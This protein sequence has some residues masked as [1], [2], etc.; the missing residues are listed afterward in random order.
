MEALPALLL[1]SRSQL[2]PARVPL[3]YAQT[4]SKQNS[5]IIEIAEG[6]LAPHADT[7]NPADR[8]RFDKALAGLKAAVA[9]QQIWL[10]TVLVP[11]ATGDFRLGTKLYDQKMKFGLMSD[12]TRP[13]LKARALAAKADIRAEMYA[14]AQQIVPAAQDGAMLPDK[15]T[16]A[17]QQAGIEA[18]LAVSY[19]THPARNQLEQR[20]RETLAQA[21]AF[22]AKAGFV[23][24]PD[25]PVKVITM[26]KFQ[27]GNTV[28]YND[29]PG[30][31]EKG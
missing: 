4:V 31:F 3:V 27:Q 12:M 20:A 18:A 28:A 15:P 29:P 13:V 7:L 14:L 1:A 10:D 30:V 26:P 8:A 21:T 25:G 17:Q 9:D 5:G 22:V 2:V 16:P 23:R 19:A 24:M 11:A 6:M